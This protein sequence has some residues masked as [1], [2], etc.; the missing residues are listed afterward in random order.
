MTFDRPDVPGAKDVRAEDA[1]DVGALDRWLRTKISGLDDA[2]G[3][4]VP[5][6]RQFR[7]GASNL[8]YLLR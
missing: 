3:P 1:F 6:V 4:G 8:T 5:Q 2:A 7:G